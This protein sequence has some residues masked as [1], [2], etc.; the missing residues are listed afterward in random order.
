MIL[1]VILAPA[2]HSIIYDLMPYS[3]L[4]FLALY[5]LWIVSYDER[6][7]VNFTWPCRAILQAKLLI[8]FFKGFDT[9]NLFKAHLDKFWLHE[10]W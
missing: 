1:L 7:K 3:N 10:D 6:Y 8:D 9:V 5:V 2:Y 4:M